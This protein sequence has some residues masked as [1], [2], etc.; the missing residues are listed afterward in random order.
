MTEHVVTCVGACVCVCVCVCVL[1]ADMWECRR[2]CVCLNIY[3]SDMCIWE[4][5]RLT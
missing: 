2:E 4:H 1:F 3:K 5:R